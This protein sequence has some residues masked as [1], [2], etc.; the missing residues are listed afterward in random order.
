M[1]HPVLDRSATVSDVVSGN[2]FDY[3]KTWYPR[4]SEPDFAGIDRNRSTAEQQ[5]LVLVLEVVVLALA[6]VPAYPER[7][8]ERLP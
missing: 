4:N 3:L 7:F 2:Q 1:N 8:L 5:A 6:V